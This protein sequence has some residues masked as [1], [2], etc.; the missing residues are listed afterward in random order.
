MSRKLDFSVFERT[1]LQKK[2][3]AI[4]LERVKAGMKLLQRK[5]GEDW[6]DKI[7]LRSLRLENCSHC[8][9]GQVYGDYSDG[10]RDL[11]LTWLGAKEDE[12]PGTYGFNSNNLPQLQNAWVNVLREM[13]V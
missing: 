11:G 8:V 3:D 4:V 9:L 5:Y 7:D 13:G 6:I 2:V 10:K 12:D 1:D